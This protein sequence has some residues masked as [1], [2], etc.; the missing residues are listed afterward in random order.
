MSYCNK[1]QAI[2]NILE[3]AKYNDN[4]YINHCIPPDDDI[5]SMSYE[6]Q[7][8]VDFLL[9]NEQKISYAMFLQDDVAEHVVLNPN[10][11]FGEVTSYD[12]YSLDEDSLNKII[13]K[14]NEAAVLFRKARKIL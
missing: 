1:F 3:K 2:V 6:E 12:T 8:H 10:S 13:A 4:I 9:N 5:Y 7:L 14:V 11:F